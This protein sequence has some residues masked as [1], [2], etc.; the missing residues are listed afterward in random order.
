M[1]ITGSTKA[2][3]FSG[4]LT[5]GGAI[6]STQTTYGMAVG[7]ISGVPRVQYTTTA[8]TFGF[9]GTNN[10]Y[11]ALRLSALAIGDDTFAGNTPSTNGAIIDGNVGIGTTAPARGL[12]L[13]TNDIT[14]GDQVSTS[15]ERGIY[16]HTGSNYGIFRE[17][18]TWTAPYEQLTV[19]WITGI[20]LHPGGGQYGRSHVG[21]VGGMS[22]GDSYYTTKEDNGLIVQGNVGI[23]TTDPGASTKLQV[24]G[25]GLF[26]GGSHDPGDGSP[27]GLSLTFE[28]D[29]G[30]IRA[31][32]TAVASYDIAIQPT[33]GG[34]V[35][36]G[37]T[38]PGS[39][40]LYVN[41]TAYV[42]TSLEVGAV[43]D[44]STSGVDVG[45]DL[46]VAGDT[47]LAGDLDMS[48]GGNFYDKDWDAGT[49]GQVL[50]SAG[51]GNG[52]YWGTD[53]SGS[54]GGGD[55]TSVIGGNAIDVSGGT[56]GDATVNHANTSNQASV[57][58]ANYTVIE[59]V[60]LDAYGHVTGLATKLVGDTTGLALV[61]YG[62]CGVK[63][64]WTEA[65]SADFDIAYPASCGGGNGS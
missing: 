22:I 39:Y 54:G 65:G 60:V 32:K 9:Y 52:V 34:N 50:H 58:C 33:S 43:L 18:G 45:V 36:I 14:F 51:D 6:R 16:W 25:R 12:D 15:G 19:S 17:T 21:V 1:L 10:S 31:V 29:V 8:N 38:A 64:T 56:S 11:A 27:K 26:T 3:T 35:A 53:D 57:Y 13:A 46:E 47:I 5:A 28:S 42:N 41:G 4:T 48:G 23:G 61:S 40:K 2:A 59:D 44:A 62:T 30:V 37:S 49:A 7:S 63:L 55:I 24:A 20:K